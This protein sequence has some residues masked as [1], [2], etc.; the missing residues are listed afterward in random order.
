MQPKTLVRKPVSIL[1]VEDD[2]RLAN[3]IQMYLGKRGCMVK[4]EENGARAVKRILNEQPDLVILDLMLPGEDGLSICRRVRVNYKGPILIL[5]AHKEDANQ[6]VGL[7]MGADD[8]VMKPV[9]PEVLFARI[10]ALLRRV[11][12]SLKKAEVDSL[13][14]GNIQ[15]NAKKREVRVKNTLVPLSS[16]E[17]DLLWFLMSKSGEILTR[18]DILE[19]MRGIPYDGVDRSIDVRIS[20][21]RSKIGDDMLN[22]MLIKTVRGRGYIF[23]RD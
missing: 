11:E 12:G 2:K 7:E 1:C 20:K 23:V 21:I 18:D 13:K 22:P 3:L 15:A 8:Y 17:F 10:R 5:T 9:H 4:I 16:S 14:I 6:I 19:S